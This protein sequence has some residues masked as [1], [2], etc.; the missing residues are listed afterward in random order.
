MSWQ[1]TVLILAALALI[2]FSFGLSAWMTNHD[3]QR[4]HEK[5]TMESAIKL[6]EMQ[7]GMLAESQ[8]TG[9]V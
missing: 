2:A 6:A 5:V 1:T 9:L 8:R 4:A 7:Q 3:R